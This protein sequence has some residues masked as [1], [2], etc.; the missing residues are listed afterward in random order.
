[1][2]VPP[3]VTGIVLAAGAGARAGGPKSLLRLNDGTPWVATAADVLLE[4]GC[5][6]VV[7][8][9]GAQA[10]LARPLVPDDRRITIVEA[11]DWADGMS[12]SLRAGLAAASDGPADAALVTLVDLPGM[13]AAA[14]KRIA[15]GATRA[16]LRQA[17]YG[18]RPGHPVLVGAQHWAAL[19][20]SLHGDHGARPWLAAHA[21][22]ELECGDIWDG[23][24][25]DEG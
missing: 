12:A 1:M 24:D 18:G 5:A 13:P 17:V 3:A 19:A 22:E 16:S 4:A 25:R 21:V 9:L 20:G 7:V 6:R 10:R 23:A 11:A 14:A 15:A 2:A 8:V